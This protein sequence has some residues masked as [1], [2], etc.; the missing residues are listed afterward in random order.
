MIDLWDG[1]H[2]FE[3]SSPVSVMVIQCTGWLTASYFIR[4]ICSLA[5]SHSFSS[6]SS[7]PFSKHIIT[8]GSYLCY[9]GVM[10]V[11]S[12]VLLINVYLWLK[13][14]TLWWLELNQCKMRA[15]LCRV[16][17]KKDW[18]NWN[19]RKKRLNVLIVKKIK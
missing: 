6:S 13:V 1:S 7:L 9:P 16:L 8:C 14:F 15:F 4:N 19:L 2:P 5:S 11:V 3:H 17:Q 10:I 18:K 12:L